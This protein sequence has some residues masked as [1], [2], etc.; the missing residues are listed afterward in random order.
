MNPVL[1]AGLILLGF[2]ILVFLLA[3]VVDLYRYSTAWRKRGGVHTERQ[4]QR[5]TYPAVGVSIILAI[6]GA[7]ATFVG[8]VLAAVG[9]A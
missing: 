6:I 5:S 1:A 4:R 2:A 8:G 9:L 7:V 3:L